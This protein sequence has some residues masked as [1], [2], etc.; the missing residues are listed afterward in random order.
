MNPIEYAALA[1]H[2][3]VKIHPF[4]D[5]NGRTGRLSMNLLLMRKGFPLAIILKPDRAQYYRALEKADV[6]NY[7]PIVGIV[8]HAVERSLL[9]YLKAISGAKKPEDEFVRLSELVVKTTYSA[10]Y[11]NLLVR[12]GLLQARKEGRFWMST[13]NALKNYER[14]KRRKSSK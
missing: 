9:I 11:L 5:G 1:H 6:G 12:K 10:K 4:E 14:S 13:Q 2:L 7:A 3:F 8:A